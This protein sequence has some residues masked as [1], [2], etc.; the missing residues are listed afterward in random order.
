MVMMGNLELVG[1]FLLLALKCIYTCMGN[2]LL[3]LKKRRKRLNRARR[4]ATREIFQSA[5]TT[6]KSRP[7]P[8]AKKVLKRKKLCRCKAKVKKVGAVNAVAS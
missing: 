2:P 3:N 6:A 7:L 8:N 4:L 1:S 5:L